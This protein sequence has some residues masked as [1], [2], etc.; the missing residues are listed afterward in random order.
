MDHRFAA[1]TT[2]WF[3][4]TLGGPLH[5]ALSP[6]ATLVACP[7]CG[8]SIC[9]SFQPTDEEA[10]LAVPPGGAVLLGLSGASDRDVAARLLVE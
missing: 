9:Q 3:A 6:G 7:A 4:V 2:T 10:P 1:T 8:S 5:V